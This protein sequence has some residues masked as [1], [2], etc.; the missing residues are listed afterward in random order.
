[1][2]GMLSKGQKVFYI[3]GNVIAEVFD[4]GFVL[5]TISIFSM[6]YNDGCPTILTAMNDD[7]ITYEDYISGERDRKIEKIID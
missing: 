4:P 6:N 2:S 5:T 1:M 7:I 3:R